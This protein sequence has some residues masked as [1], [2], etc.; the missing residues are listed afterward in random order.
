MFLEILGEEVF[1]R[2]GTFL[3]VNLLS[4]SCL[5]CSPSFILIGEARG[6]IKSVKTVTISGVLD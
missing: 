3:I 1:K 2:V 4:Q 6:Q 5:S